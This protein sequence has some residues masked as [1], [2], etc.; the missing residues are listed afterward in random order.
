MHRHP[1]GYASLA[2]RG[3]YW[4]YDEEYNRNSIQPG[5]E[6]AFA[7]LCIQN[8]S[9]DDRFCMSPIER[10]LREVRH[11]IAVAEREYGRKAGTV[12]LL[13]V[14]KTR[15]AEEIAEAFRC[16]QKDFGENY[17]QEAV[18]KK[19]RLGEGTLRWHFI[20]RIQSNK[21]RAIAEHFDWVHSLCDTGH[22]RRLNDQR[23]KDLPPLQVCIQVNV[24]GEQSKA[25]VEP[26]ELQPLVAMLSELERSGQKMTMSE[27]SREL[28]VSNGNVTGVID[29]LEKNGF[30]TR[31]RAEHDRRIQYIEL[32]PKGRHEFDDMAQR[33]EHWLTEMFAELSLGDMAEMRKLLL[34]TRN[35]VSA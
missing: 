27:L 29:R 20:G 33:H 6:V 8:T 10:R 25:G 28:M 24:S 21:T 7:L 5:N 11:R 35:S 23:P 19:R 18:E 4:T 22:A 32:T 1:A 31:T 3:K 2:S 14:S 12:R 26:E 13:A 15:S 17:L 9:I 30:V 16:G 34:K